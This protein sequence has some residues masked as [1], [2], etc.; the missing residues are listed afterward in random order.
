MGFAAVWASAVPAGI[1]PSSSGRPTATPAPRRK[2]RREM[3]FLVMN[4]IHLLRCCVSDPLARFA[5]VS[6]SRGGDYFI[7]PLCEGESRRRRQGVAHTQSRIGQHG[8]ITG[9]LLDPSHLKRCTLC[10]A[11][12]DR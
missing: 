9:Y 1:I 3:N 11:N 2:V 7:L 10:D 12:N 4:M 6:P 5:R 8:L